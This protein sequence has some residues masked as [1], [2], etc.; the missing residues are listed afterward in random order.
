MTSIR[1]PATEI[2]AGDNYYLSCDTGVRVDHI[3][4]VRGRVQIHT[5]AGLLATV[6]RDAEVRLHGRGIAA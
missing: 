5:A 2:Q 4:I 3:A 1:I 6:K